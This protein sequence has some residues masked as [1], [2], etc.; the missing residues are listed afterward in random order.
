MPNCI[1]IECSKIHS[2]ILNDKKIIA[3]FGVIGQTELSP[4]IFEMSS[5]SPH[6]LRIYVSYRVLMVIDFMGFHE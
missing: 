1:F 3:I 4:S 6:S 5:D 2:K